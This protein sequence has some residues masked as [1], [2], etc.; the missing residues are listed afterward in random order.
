M[1]STEAS[2]RLKSPSFDTP[3]LSPPSLI[4]RQQPSCAEPLAQFQLL[5]ELRAHVAVRVMDAGNYSDPNV[6]TS[7]SPA[8]KSPKFSLGRSLLSVTSCLVSKVAPSPEERH[9]TIEE[10]AA[11]TVTFVVRHLP[12]GVGAGEAVQ[13]LGDVIVSYPLTMLM[14][15]S[16][17]SVPEKNAFLFKML[18]ET[19]HPTYATESSRRTKNTDLGITSPPTSS[20]FVSASGE[21]GL[22][23]IFKETLAAFPL[24]KDIFRKVE[25]R[26]VSPRERDLWLN[27]LEK[28]YAT[29]LLDSVRTGGGVCL[30][31][32]EM[33]KLTEESAR[34]MRQKPAPAV[35]ER[36]IDFFLSF[37]SREDADRTQEVEVVDPRDVPCGGILRI[38]LGENHFET[39]RFAYKKNK[40]RSASAGHTLEE[41]EEYLVMH[42]TTV[43]QRVRRVAKYKVPIGQLRVMVEEEHFGHAFFL[44]QTAEVTSGSPKSL[45]SLFHS[46]PN[47]LQLAWAT[48]PPEGSNDFVVT[49]TIELHAS[50]FLNR[51]RWLKWFEAVLRKPVIYLSRLREE[52]KSLE[53]IHD[54]RRRR[55]SLFLEPLPTTF[56]GD[57]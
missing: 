2:L 28:F 11:H 45:L 19:F 43:S 52:K 42:P 26:F 10:A 5:R 4:E 46:Q 16:T 13:E 47:N 12:K 33:R 48:S 14:D 18:P 3:P 37:V 9:I 57:D 38:D 8:K 30:C 35:I 53:R 56:A 21:V 23:L 32:S 22:Q 55:T 29:F 1:A 15:V 51:I 50:G 36:Y 24:A 31:D 41:E 17:F 39:R 25:M 20:S 34:L 40:R 6:S 7:S 27:C 54:P 44:E 49:E